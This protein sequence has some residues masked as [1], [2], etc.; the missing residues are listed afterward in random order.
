MK[1][2]VISYS[3]IEFSFFQKTD[4]KRINTIQETLSGIQFQ[5]NERLKG[6]V[7]KAARL[8]NFYRSNEGQKFI[9]YLLGLDVNLMKEIHKS[10]KSVIAG[11]MRLILSTIFRYFS[12]YSRSEHKLH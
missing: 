12:F 9:V 1:K 10:I 5:E 7:C 8:P 4:I 11:E 2:L 3:I 6:Y